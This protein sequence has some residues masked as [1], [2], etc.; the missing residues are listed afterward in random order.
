MV[1]VHTGHLACD[2][3]NCM[4]CACNATDIRCIFQE[5]NKPSIVMGRRRQDEMHCS[6]QPLH[7]NAIDSFKCSCARMAMNINLKKRRASWN[8]TRAL[9]RLAGLHTFIFSRA[10]EAQ[11]RFLHQKSAGARPHCIRLRQ[12]SPLAHETRNVQKISGMPVL[13]AHRC[14]SRLHAQQWRH[15]Q[16]R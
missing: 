5:R 3:H 2:P 8:R 6:I 11:N 13:A 14:S 1:P 4:L 10:Q 7:R 15:R 16:Q 9:H 12:R